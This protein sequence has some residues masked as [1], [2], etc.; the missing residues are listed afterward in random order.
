MN[1][2]VR[3]SLF[4]LFLL[5]LIFRIVYVEKIPSGF[6]VDEVRVGQNAYSL[7]QT[8]K[9][10]YGNVLPISY[11]SFNENRPT[12]IFYSTIP[13]VITFG[14]T[15]FATRLPTAIYGALSVIALYVVV[16]FITGSKRSA[17]FSAIFLTFSAW[18]ILLSRATSEAIG[19]VF[20]YLCALGLF[21]YTLKQKNTR[22]R[23]HLYI[24]SIVLLALSFFFYPSARIFVPLS[25]ISLLSLKSLHEYKKQIGVA[26]IVLFLLGFIG[27][28]FLT[29][30]NSRFSQV[31]LLNDP[32]YKSIQENVNGVNEQSRGMASKVFNNTPLVFGKAF[33]S[34]YVSYINPNFLI[35]DIFRPGRYTFSSAQLLTVS[36]L[37]VLVIGV[38]LLHKIKSLR[39]FFLWILCGI[40]PAAIT[41]E[42]APNMQRAIF[43]TIGIYGVCG[44]TLNYIIEKI[45]WKP[46]IAI[47]VCIFLFEWL[48]FVYR[49]TTEQK[50]YEPILRNE[51]SLPLSQFLV[52]KYDTYDK[53]VVTNTPESLLPYLLFSNIDKKVK[54][55]PTYS[56]QDTQNES[57][58]YGK[59][60]F[61]TKTCPSSELKIKGKPNEKILYVDTG[62][63][64]KDPKKNLELIKTFIYRN[65]TKA[66]SLYATAKA[67]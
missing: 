10:Q 7:S 11:N 46:L 60:Q 57:F 19:S 64:T 41:Y 2:F 58:V 61:V 39:V 12:G 8:A 52:E 53:I 21:L 28:T 63:C 49:Y 5:A 16:F 35:S 44:I 50:L 30:N 51:Q 67:K 37:I 62:D 31:L 34:S 45:K 1:N 20:W 32:H 17:I 9:D 27:F 13:S 26:S 29:G 66:Y 56:W 55:K 6:H 25:L 33:I 48:I 36:E 40:L 24:G 65:G 3:V 4:A 47:V 54:N 14:K 23:G 18:N 22:F 59:I 38:L 43:M 42:D 15:V